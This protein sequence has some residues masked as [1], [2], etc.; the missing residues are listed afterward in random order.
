MNPS[1]APPVLKLSDPG[2]IIDAVPFLTGFH[3][4][5]SLV[6]LSLRQPRRRLGLTMRADLGPAAADPDFIGRTLEAMQRDGAT[7]AVV[8]VLSEDGED[9]S[10]LP[11]RELVTGLAD[12]LVAAGVEVHEQLCV[13][14]GRWFSY[15]CLRSCC[16]ADGTPLRVGTSA[17]AAQSVL[18]GRVVLPDRA[19]LAATVAG[20]APGSPVAVERELLLADLAQEQ[21]EDLLAGA[22]ERDQQVRAVVASFRRLM[23]SPFATPDEVA[24][25]PLLVG[26][27]SRLV[28]DEVLATVT[29]AEL[30]Q[31]IALCSALL[32]VAVPPWTEVPA[33]MLAWCAWRQGGGAL[34]NI[35]VDRVLASDPQCTLAL[36]VAFA[37][38]HG[39]RADPEFGVGVTSG[40]TAVPQLP[41]RRERRAG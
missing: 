19:A 8:V 37:L 38:L 17:L 16:P 23:L 11:W 20:P 28:R 12:A 36:H 7:G 27:D 9:P 39:M 32:R 2:S 14:R 35:A 15:S 25:L 30:P 26:L 41:R 10:A 31:A 18:E 5:Q 1:D 4:A 40:T 21:A 6:V 29:D 24:L 13:R 33:T 34:A 3:P 22:V